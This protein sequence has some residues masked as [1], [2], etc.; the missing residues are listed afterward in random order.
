MPVTLLMLCRTSVVMGALHHR[1]MMAV[2][3]LACSSTALPTCVGLPSH[4]SSSQKSIVLRQF[5]SGRAVAR[6]GTNWV[7]SELRQAPMKNIE[8][9]GECGICHFKRFHH[10]APVKEHICNSGDACQVHAL[11]RADGTSSAFSSNS[12]RTVGVFEAP[13]LMQCIYVTK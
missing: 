3:R 8:E 10:E 9:R 6:R 2:R 12:R 5:H 13:T 7:S 1:K 4:V 11:N